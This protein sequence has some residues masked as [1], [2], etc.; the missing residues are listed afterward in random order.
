MID[1]AAIVSELATILETITD[2]KEVHEGIPGTWGNYPAASI[3]PV[4]WDEEYADLRDTKI[5]A[6][7]R[8]AVYVTYSAGD[9]LP[10]AQQTLWGIVKQ[11][12]EELGKQENIDLSGNID[13]SSLSSGSFLFDNKEANQVYCLIDYKATKRFN[14]HA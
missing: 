1:E 10:G 4:S 9:D 6:T 13:F 2:I 5:V 12:K 8:I 3:Y 14:R 11:I 7:F